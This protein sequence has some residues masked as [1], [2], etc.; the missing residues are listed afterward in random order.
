M[1]QQYNPQHINYALVEGTRPP[2]Y[3][4][5]KYWG[6][7]P[8]NIW[9]DY[10]AHYCPEDGIVLDPFV[11]SGITAF[12]AL[13][14]GRN[15][16]ATD[17]NPLSS[18]VIETMTSKFDEGAFTS[19][20]KK[21]SVAV[22]AD[23][24]YQKHYTKMLDG[25][26]CTVFNYIWNM[27]EVSLVRMKDND[28][29]G[30]SV[31]ADDID[32]EN[33]RTLSELNIPY[34]YPEDTF[35]QNPS[36]NLNFINKIGGN[37]FDNIWTRRNLYVLSMIFDLILK[38]DA[39]IQ[40]Q[41]LYAFIHTLHL[42]SKMVVPRAEKGN[43]DFSGS[44]GRADYMIRNRS[45]EQ[46]PLVVFERSC[47]DK[48]G[49]VKA[50]KDANK[51][52]PIK[53]KLN[54]INA[55][56]RITA[57]DLNYGV[58]DIADLTDVVADNSVDFI[59]T[60]PP[61]GGL[62]QYMD[63]SMVWLVWLKKYDPK[64]TP[65]SSGEITYKKGITSRNTYKRKLVHAFRNMYRVLKPDHYMVVTFHNQ[66]IQEWNDFVSAIR[67][68]GFQFEKVTHQYNKRSG[69]S[70]VSNPYGTTGSDF[71]IRCKKITNL[72]AL[73]GRKELNLFVINKVKEILIERAEPTPFTFVMNGLLPDMLQAGYLE[74]EQ[75][76]E[77]IMNILAPEIGVGKTFSVTK[78][79]KNQS[80]DIL[81]FNNPSQHISHRNISLTERVDLTV[82][83]LLRRKISVKYDD[84]VAE[85]FK[86]FPNGQTPDPKGIDDVVAKYATKSNSKWKLK[87]EV[88][89]ECTEHTFVIS[90]LCSLA[91][92]AKSSS[93]VGKREQREFLENGQK[94][95]DIATY[96]N[97]DE[98]A[99]IY[100]EEQLTRILMI[101]TLWIRD[102]EIQAV[103]EVENSTGFIEA[104]M[105]SSN[106]GRNIP[107]FMIVP[108]RRLTEFMRF[109]DPLF[110][111][112]FNENNWKYLTY[113]D[114]K[115]LCS[116]RTI[117][118]DKIYEL[119]KSR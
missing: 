53:A 88:E 55:R 37:T 107:K 49:V 27:G 19:A 2:M 98:L 40:K 70:N 11:G 3:S 91:Q 28:G 82:K 85:I 17:L 71:Y 51:Q 61:Y 109:N 50:M 104:I 115:L 112:S 94:L 81:W 92:K 72:H 62:V 20:I 80:G 9:N 30:Y 31:D 75:P 18:F 111:D 102:N 87:D 116:S 16:I 119:A 84:V 95:S 10:I 117:T 14:L 110:V 58:W 89:R 44:W 74:F 23:E 48:Q 21:I 77:E 34:W 54:Y 108:D 5:M 86:E 26:L 66:E 97:L 106:I 36:I 8:H 63:L 13:K 83:S 93:F 29:N 24:V 22:K 45:M 73:P 90:Q 76:A 41:L 60:D 78:N 59:L 101:D 15:V 47:F 57:A 4:A 35:P 32:K 68:V 64:Y 96:T 7:K 12:E 38:E 52:L 67:E 46:N 33:A 65:D 43:R 99:S 56:N 42:V 114:V 100:S 69:E 1:A 103:F 105:R 79:S 6:R 113:E 118:L 25:N 39:K